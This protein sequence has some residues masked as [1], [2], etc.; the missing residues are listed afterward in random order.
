MDFDDLLQVLASFRK[1]DVEYVLIGAAALSIHNII[2]ATDDVDIFL[3]PDA[4]NVDRLRAALAAVF[5]DPEIEKIT[6]ED[7][8]GDYPAVQY[9]TPDGRF[10]LDVLTRLGDAFGWDD[11]HS[12]I[13]DVRSVPVR[14]ATPRTLYRM[15]RGTARP[16]DR[17][18]ALMLR[19]AF[20]F[21]DED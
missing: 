21:S 5:G 15:K 17:L 14:V 19:E 10:Q 9:V 12:E 7:L 4:G 6:A 3:R 18:D 2:R 1:H 16:K 8:L 11:L 20:G 13:V